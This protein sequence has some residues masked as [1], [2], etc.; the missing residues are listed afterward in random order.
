MTAAV[1]LLVTAVW[2]FIVW[3]PFLRRVIRDPRAKDARG[4]ATR[5]L[6]VHI[7]L[8]GVSLVL[9]LACGIMGLALLAG[10]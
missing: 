9:A 3:P 6:G 1:L 8:I 4:K 2:S 5:F 10:E 7:V